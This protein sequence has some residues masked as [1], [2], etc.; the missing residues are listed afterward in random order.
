MGQDLTWTDG[1]MLIGWGSGSD[2]ARFGGVEAF[3]NRT[4]IQA[5]IVAQRMP[6]AR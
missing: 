6:Q 3:R 1:A 4:C 5:V 2:R